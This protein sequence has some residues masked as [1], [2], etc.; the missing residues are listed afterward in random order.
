MS[1]ARGTAADALGALFAAV[2]TF[3]VS[4][5]ASNGVSQPHCCWAATWRA[6]SK[7]TD[8][9]SSTDEQP[10]RQPE[11][12]ITEDGEAARLRF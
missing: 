10:T 6:P 9:R 4:A 12:L 5:V 3:S 11:S 1:Q 2:P 7:D 8:P